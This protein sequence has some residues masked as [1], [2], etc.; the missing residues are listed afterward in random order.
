MRCRSLRFTIRHLLIL[1]VFSA[2]LSKG[3]AS[4]MRGKP[5]APAEIV[6]SNFKL[7]WVWSPMILGV[8]ILLLERPGPFK[9]WLIIISIAWWSFLVIAALVILTDM[10]CLSLNA[11]GFTNRN[12]VYLSLSVF[13]FAVALPSIPFRCPGCRRQATFPSIRPFASYTES[14]TRCCACCGMMSRKGF[15]RDW[16]IIEDES[17]SENPLS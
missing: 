11:P 14:R 1:V 5:V 7:Y 10:A 6:L 9:Y 4:A 16:E 8:L 13:L 17:A 2:F 15:G 12:G 3:F